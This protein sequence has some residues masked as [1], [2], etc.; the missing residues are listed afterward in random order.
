MID[1]LINVCRAFLFTTALPPSAVTA[2]L[3]ALNLL[4]CDREMVARLWENG[5]RLRN[6]L[7]GLG[8]DTLSSDTHIVPI[9]I[10]DAQETIEVAAAL[11]ERGVFVVAIR[12]PTVPAGQSRLRASVMATHTADDISFALDA[13]AAVRPRVR[14][15]QVA[16]P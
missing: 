16:H 1:Y 4:E 6:G 13:F 9:L 15:P 10:G 8:F 5:D 7:G 3:A 2:A 12:P 14:P 11:R